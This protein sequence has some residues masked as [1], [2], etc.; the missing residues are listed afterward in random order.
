MIEQLF[1][2]TD[3]ESVIVWIPF[4]VNLR[5]LQPVPMVPLHASPQPIPVS[6][7]EE[8]PALLPPPPC[9]APVE[10]KPRRG[11]ASSKQINLIRDIARKRQM[12]LE[13]ICR[14]VGAPSIEQMTNAQ[15]HSAI[16]K[17]MDFPF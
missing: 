12:S 16:K 3:D 1:Q 17:Y 13:D 7:A 2:N 9:K 5:N 6:A 8:R 14:E 4:I 15:A 10:R 11:L